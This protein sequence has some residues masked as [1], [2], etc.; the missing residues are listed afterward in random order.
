MWKGFSSLS[1][2]VFD[3][4]DLVSQTCSDCVFDECDFAPLRESSKVS[5]TCQTVCLTKKRWVARFG[6]LV[7][8]LFLCGKLCVMVALLRGR[9]CEWLVLVPLGKLWVGVA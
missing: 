2:C 5:L 4:N 3:E 6:N 1:N 9:T 7:I 8:V